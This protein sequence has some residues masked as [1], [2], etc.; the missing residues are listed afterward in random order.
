MLAAGTRLGAYEILAPLGAGG[1]GEVYRARDTRLGREIAVKIVSERLANDPDA[2]ARFEREAR[3]VAALTHPNIVA[4]HDVGR[5]G[6]VAFAVTELLEGAPLDQC[7]G[8]GLTSQKALEIAAAIADG[9]AFAHAKGVIHR[10]LK[11]ANVFI[12]TDGQV[13][14]LDFG[15]ARSNPFR[16]HAQAAG[17]TLPAETDP[18]VVLGTMSYMSPEQVMGEPADERSDIFSLGCVIYE[19]LTGR[20]PFRG[21]RPAETVASILR[22]ETADL[23]RVRRDIPPRVAAL[24]GRCMEKNPQRRFQSARDLAFSL[25]ETP[26]SAVT[27]PERI[28]ATIGQR[29]VWLLAA[30]LLAASA[31]VFWNSRASAPVPQDAAR[32]RSLAVL[33][34]KNLSGDP[35]QDYFADAMTEELTTRLAKMGTW[36]VTSRTSVM[37]YRGTPKTIPAIARELGVDAVID[38]S[39]IRDGSRVKVTAQLIDGATDQHIWAETYERDLESVLAIQSEVARAIAR[40]VGWSLTPEGSAGLVAATRPV[41][42]AA[43]DAYLRGR[44]ALD[45][46]SEADLREALQFFQQSVDA[47]PT[48]AP[49]Y[50]GLAD[51]YGQLGYGSYIAPEDSFPRA[52][53][54]AAK[55]LELD[56]TLGEAHASLGFVL[57]YFDWNFARAETE[58]KQAIA[59][60]Q[61]SAIAHQWYAYL[62]T[63]MEKPVSEAEREI[64]IARSL[65]PLSVPIHIDRAYIL[66]Y[67]AR[68]DEA[69]RSVKVALAMNPK[70]SMGYFWL[71]RIYTAQG[72]YEDAHAALQ[73]IGPLR[74]WTPGMAA[75]GYLYGKS[76][77]TQEAR[78]VLTEFD[79]LVRQDRYAS[80]YAIAAVHAGLGDRERVFASLDAAFRERSHWLVW[81]K[82]DPRWNDVHT[83]PRFQALVQRIGLPS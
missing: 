62:L 51:S 69:L 36:R 4:L 26:T 61:N 20:T 33:P 18:G 8:T 22:D 35:R 81:L 45:K 80:A 66:H 57:M 14:I 44:H 64:A 10:D 65:D 55:A 6:G 48:Y 58:F 13:K 2:L 23:H 11:P 37:G 27:G 52:R 1:M 71:G 75:L 3:T 78:S 21:E 56:P 47:D 16:T 76:G 59:L 83:D 17:T 38:G 24:V 40:S 19:M 7:I 30:V 74:T 49:A 46:R 63:A 77:R 42:P 79:D 72:R 60:N 28:I 29:G 54:A 82:R 39:V 68:N 53:A 67:Y 50:A 12:T 31:A 70:I 73:S 9:L 43:Y 32:I 34:L 25:R 41:L 15:L 5:E